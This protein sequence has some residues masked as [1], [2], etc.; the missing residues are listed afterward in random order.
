MDISFEQCRF[1]RRPDLTLGTRNTVPDLRRDISFLV[2]RDS[3]TLTTK[4]D[5]GC[6]PTETSANDGDV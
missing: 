5:G 1:E 4:R 3:M 2:H 6:E